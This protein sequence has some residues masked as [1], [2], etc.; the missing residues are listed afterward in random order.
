MD[1]AV[2]PITLDD[3]L[4]RDVHEQI[5]R[6]FSDFSMFDENMVVK[7]LDNLHRAKNPV[8]STQN[9]KKL[10]E[11]AMENCLRLTVP[12]KRKDLRE[13]VKEQSVILKACHVLVL[14]VQR[15]M[16]SFKMTSVQELLD[17]YPQFNGLDVVELKRL[18]IFRNMMKIALL[19]IPAKGYKQ[20]LLKIAGRL[21]GSQKDYVTGGGQTKE[22]CR[23]V[24]VYEHEGGVRAE[25]KRSVA[26]ES[27]GTEPIPRK[28]KSRG[29][30]DVA[31]ASEPSAPCP[32][33]QRQD[34]ANIITPQHS[35]L[36]CLSEQLPFATELQPMELE[37][38][39]CADVLDDWCFEFNQLDACVPVT[40]GEAWSGSASSCDETTIASIE[41]EGH[42]NDAKSLFFVDSDDAADDRDLLDFLSLINDDSDWLGQE[43]YD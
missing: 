42:M 29:D 38:A 17:E 30:S 12:T 27:V 10:E 25:K 36:V 39:A 4:C 40:E 3:K 8:I 31:A 24:A 33:Q 32:E 21:E 19:V 5:K 18:L 2:Y 11:I 41:S 26:L 16:N 7:T 1:N 35:P 22:T 23:R 9:T 28:R 34:A 37:G 13:Q 14:A 43:V 6:N 20:V 15:Q